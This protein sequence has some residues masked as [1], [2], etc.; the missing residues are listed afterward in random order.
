MTKKLTH[1]E[2]VS[3][4]NS[5]N[6]EIIVLEQ[7]NGAHY[8]NFAILVFKPKNEMPILLPDNWFL[9]HHDEIK[10]II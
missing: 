3:K 8:Y 1:E 2:Y 10:D 7:Y 9:L 5:I 4:L 6:K